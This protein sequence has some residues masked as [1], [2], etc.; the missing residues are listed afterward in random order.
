MPTESQFPKAPPLRFELTEEQA[1]LIEEAKPPGAV[2]L[3]VG[4]AQRHPWPEPDR[5]TLCAWLVT[6][7]KAEAAL[8]A[9]GIIATRNRPRPKKPLPLQTYAPIAQLRH[10]KTKKISPP[11]AES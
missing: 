10:L 1:A 7:P 5:F 2:A 8:M 6:M 3:V 4:Y 9:G 11:P